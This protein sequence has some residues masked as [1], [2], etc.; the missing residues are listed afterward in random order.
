MQ[1]YLEVGMWK[2]YILGIETDIKLVATEAGIATRLVLPWVI[3]A[4]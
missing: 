4:W 2:V 1:G 3:A